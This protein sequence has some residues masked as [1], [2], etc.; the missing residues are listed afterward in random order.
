[1]IWIIYTPDNRGHLQ[2]T[3]RRVAPMQ[4][5]ALANGRPPKDCPVIISLIMRRWLI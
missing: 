4:R 1:M 5:G 2:I 3:M